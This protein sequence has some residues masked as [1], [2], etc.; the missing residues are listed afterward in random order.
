MLVGVLDYSVLPCFLVRKIKA[1]AHT[2]NLKK[3]N[4]FL[5]LYRN[6][7]FMNVSSLA[8]K[9]STLMDIVC[10]NIVGWRYQLCDY[11]CAT[12]Q[13]LDII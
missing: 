4:F 12:N 5:S 3:K 8:I 13:F 10:N 1:F 6:V 2:L 9:K 11:A 7:R